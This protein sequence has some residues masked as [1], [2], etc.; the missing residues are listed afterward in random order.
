MHARQHDFLRAPI[1]RRLDIRDHIRQRTRTTFTARN[2][3]DAESAVII[4]A[5]LHLDESAGALAQTGQ[6]LASNRFQIEGFIWQIEK[7]GNQ[8]FF[9]RIIDYT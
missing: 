5:V 7:F 2:S 1:Q 4:T 6:R 8:R 9:L 3:R